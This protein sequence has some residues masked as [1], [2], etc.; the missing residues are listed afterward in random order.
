MKNN[1]LENEQDYD[2]ND[3]S[4]TELAAGN[5]DDPSNAIDDDADLDDDTDLDDDLDLEDDSDLDEDDT[6][7]FEDE[8]LSDADVGGAN[9][10]L[11]GTQSSTGQDTEDDDPI[12]NEDAAA[13]SA[14]GDNM[15]NDPDFTGTRDV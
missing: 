4:A 2:Q 6:E 13:Q 9:A 12:L 5:G 3:L 14:Y 7:D 10:D 15:D 11:G 1:Q 8:E